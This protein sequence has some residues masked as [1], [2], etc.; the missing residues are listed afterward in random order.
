M[1][2]SIHSPCLE[3][4]GAQQ[5][6]DSSSATVLYCDGTQGVPKG[7][8]TT[9]APFKLCYN[10]CTE[11]Q[12]S[13]WH[14]QRYVASLILQLYLTLALHIYSTCILMPSPPLSSKA[15]LFCPPS[16]GPFLVSLPLPIFP[17]KHTH[18]PARS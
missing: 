7:C 6:L 14:S 13:S 17:H 15:S 5:L 8:A 2:L 16:H 10:Q 9:H 12:V 1:R 18:I 4:P 3:L 11:Y